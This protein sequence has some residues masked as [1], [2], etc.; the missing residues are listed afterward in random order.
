MFLYYEN[1][2]HH[3]PDVLSNKLPFLSYNYTSCRF[4]VSHQGVYFS[5]KWQ[6]AFFHPHHLDLPTPSKSANCDLTKCVF[7]FL[8]FSKQ[9]MGTSGN[10]F[11]CP[12]LDGRT[13]CNSTKTFPTSPNTGWYVMLK[14]ILLLL[15]INVL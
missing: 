13:S 15:A 2:A 1:I 11:L 14:L 4:Y 6:E 8:S 7:K 9:F 3:V 5:H 10:I 12:S